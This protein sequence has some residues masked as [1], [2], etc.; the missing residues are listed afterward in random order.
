MLQGLLYV[1]RANACSKLFQTSKLWPE[2]SS[3]GGRGEERLR[4]S[5][6]GL[7]VVVQLGEILNLRLEGLERGLHRCM[8]GGRKSAQSTIK[9]GV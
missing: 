9:W 6:D 2:G 1:G 5:P 8:S 3:S 4:Q 7:Q